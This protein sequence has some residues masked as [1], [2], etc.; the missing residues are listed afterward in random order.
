ML[1]TIV[2]SIVPIQQNKLFLS[3]NT[4]AIINLN[5]Q[6]VTLIFASKN[7]INLIQ[8]YIFNDGLLT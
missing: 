1:S 3:Q 2:Y 4:K 6:T 8:K 7:K 5:D